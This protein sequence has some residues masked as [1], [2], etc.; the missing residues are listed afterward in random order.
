MRPSLTGSVDVHIPFA[1]NPTSAYQVKA[2]DSANP[3]LIPQ[4]PQEQIA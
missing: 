2:P 3:G 1:T 4:L